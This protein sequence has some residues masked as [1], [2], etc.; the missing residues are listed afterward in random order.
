MPDC[1][2][3]VYNINY[4]PPDNASGSK[5]GIA[6]FLEQYPNAAAVQAFLAKHSPRRNE[7]GYSSNYNFTI[8]S[9]NGGAVD[10]NGGGVEA[11]L[12]TEYIMPFTQPLD[13]TYFSVGGRGPEIDSNGNALPANES[14]NEPWVEFV[15]YLI[16]K[17]DV[18]QVISISYTDDEQAIPLPYAQRVCDLFMQLAARGVSVLVASGDGGAAGI[19]YGDCQSNDGKKTHKFIPTFPVDCPYVTGVGA[20]A[21]YFPQ[22]AASFSSG[23][24]SEYF[25][26]PAWQEKAA[27]AYIKAINGSHDGWYKPSG[28][29]IPDISAIGSRYVIGDAKFEWTQSGTSASTPVVA[30]IFALINDQRLRAGKPVLGF[31]NPLLYSANVSARHWHWSP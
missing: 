23:G 24:F 8:E 29:A 5:I 25:P 17:E 3:E 27:S 9:V 16:A 4:I 18:P 14:E 28:R 31:L 12:D 21:S 22:G 26:R 19:R 30:S 11:I 2:A 13:V 15:E 6:G 20:T 7:T 1:V 10:Y